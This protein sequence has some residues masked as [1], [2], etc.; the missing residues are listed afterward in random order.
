MAPRAAS[1]LQSLGFEVYE[2]KAGKQDWL[3][4]GLPT[5]GEKAAE[6]RAGGVAR[7][8]VPT[9]GTH[10]RLGEVV[11]RV[12]AAGWDAAV[13]VD[14]QD[15]VLGILRRKELAKDPSVLVVEAMLAGPSTFRPNVPIAEM[16][17]YM[18]EHKLE[19]S[20]VTTADGTLIGLLYRSDAVAAAERAGS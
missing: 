16:A 12:R 4:A 20:P 13:V 6:P 7:K 8:S 10:D 5:E 14:R 18:A 2:Y 1:R 11:E 17:G 15:V 3:T 19:S 9:C